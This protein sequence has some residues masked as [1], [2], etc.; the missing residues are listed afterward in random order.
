MEIKKKG[1]KIKQDIFPKI[2]DQGSSQTRLLSTMDYEKGK[3]NIVVLESKDQ[4]KVTN[5]SIDLNAINLVDKM[6]LHRQTREMLNIDV[7]IASIGMKKL[8]TINEKIRNQ[9]KKKN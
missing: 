3:L 6:D 9:L 5:I 1:V 2:Y 4:N 8:Q 7:M